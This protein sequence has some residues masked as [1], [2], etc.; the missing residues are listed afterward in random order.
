MKSSKIALCQLIPDYDKKTSLVKAIEMI[1]RSAEENADIAI[2][3]EMF[4]HP[5][6]LL[7]ILKKIGDE[8]VV[9]EKLS[10]CAKKN[11][12]HICSGSMAVRQNG[13]IYNRSYLIDSG[14]KVILKYDKCHLFDVNLPQLRARESLVFTPGSD[15][16]VVESAIGKIGIVI[17]YDIRFPELIRSLTLK[18][19]EL[20]IVPAVFNNVTG[21]AHWSVMM[22]ARAIENQFFI[23][24]VSQG[25]NVASSYISYGHSMVV[26]P[27]G[28]V[29]CEASD[30]GEIVYAQIDAETLVQTRAYLPLL[31]H[32][33]GDLYQ[34]LYSLDGV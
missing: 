16:P 13:K 7:A 14:G 17:C 34:K 31:E 33:R 26:S 5:Y 3:P 25:R 15:A 10:D 27:W 11:G 29:L 1:E 6:E 32:R 21:P 28:D 4:Y 22:R 24:A 23:A 18:G 20:L 19:A 30:G 2:L 12:I 9:L 8:E